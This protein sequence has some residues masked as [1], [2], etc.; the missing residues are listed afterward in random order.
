MRQAMNTGKE[1]RR[2]RPAL[3]RVRIQLT[4]SPEIRDALEQVSQTTNIT[5]SQC[6]EA[7]LT[8][9][10]KRQTRRPKEV[11]PILTKVSEE[12]APIDPEAI[13]AAM[14]EGLRQYSKAPFVQSEMRPFE[15]GDWTDPLFDWGVD[16]LNGDKL[17]MLILLDTWYDQTPAIKDLQGNREYIQR[18]HDRSKANPDSIRRNDDPTLWNLFAPL[19]WSRREIDSGGCLLGNLVP[20]FWRNDKPTGALSRQIYTR[21]LR[22]LWLPL[23]RQYRPNTIYL[24]GSWARKLGKKWCCDLPDCQIKNACHPSS[25][26]PPWNGPDGPSLLKEC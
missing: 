9:W 7:A 16:Q 26:N 10:I 4:L 3:H 5:Q 2:G 6:V 20:G 25:W 12:P 15:G 21:A 18:F 1:H 11:V 24:C 23:I 14:A 13:R 8:D 17:A 19:S 22:V